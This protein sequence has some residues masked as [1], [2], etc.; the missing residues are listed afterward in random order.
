M[1]QEI[2]ILDVFHFPKGTTMAIIDCQREPMI[3]DYIVNE[4]C[5]P[6]WKIKGVVIH[7]KKSLNIKPTYYLGNK[8]YRR[9]VSLVPLEKGLQLENGDSYYLKSP[10]L[11]L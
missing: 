3:G 4:E 10:P 9:S 1:E 7:I 2:K 6:L 5:T 11:L 8:N